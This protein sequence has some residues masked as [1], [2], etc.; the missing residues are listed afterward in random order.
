GNRGPAMTVN[1][2][3]STF[4]LPITGMSCASCVGRVERA[5]AKIPGV[6]A[7]TVNL[8]TEQ[9]RVEAPADSLPQLVAAI[10]DAGYEVSR[11]QLDLD[12]Q[13]MSCA[14]CVGRIERALTAQ[15]GVLEVSVN[16]ASGR[17]RVT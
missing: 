9:A 11:Q 6:Q 4:T 8:A 10:H 16:L 14:A 1:Q 13:G 17:A 3:T 15:P 12:I 5:L 7:S 2:T